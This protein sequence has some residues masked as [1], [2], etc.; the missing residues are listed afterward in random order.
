M[1][2]PLK[3]WRRSQ[4]PKVTLAALA[5]QVGVTASHL[6]EVENYNN[7]PSLD[8]T[9][10]LSDI[11][12]IEMKSFVNPSDAKCAEVTECQPQ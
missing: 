9:S 6:S 10:R 8:L 1:E 12:G 11:T 7:E 4:I 3:A 5:Q 2:H